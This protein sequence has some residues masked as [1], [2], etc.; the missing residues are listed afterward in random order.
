MASS[1]RSVRSRTA[2][3][4]RRPASQAEQRRARLALVDGGRSAT[5]R[6]LGGRA[7]RFV[8]WAGTRSTPLI[9]FAVA[10][11]FLSVCLLGSLLLRTQMVQNSFEASSVQSSISKLTQDVQDDQDKL[12]QLQA[13]LP[14]K[15]QQMGMVPQRGTSSIDL[16]GYRPSENM[17]P[18]NQGQAPGARAGQH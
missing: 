7:R 13:S 4:K 15:A 8:S 2:P 14:D 3:G 10:L 6:S 12:D 1:A 9:Q 11:V 17:Q 5:N 16:N 18:Q